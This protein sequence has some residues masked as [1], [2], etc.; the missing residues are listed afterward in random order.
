MDN[1]D[2][3]QG[4]DQ[5]VGQSGWRHQE[6]TDAQRRIEEQQRREVNVGQRNNDLGKRK[7]NRQPGRGRRD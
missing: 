3:K 7:R 6:E 1:D 4:G 5:G 2:V